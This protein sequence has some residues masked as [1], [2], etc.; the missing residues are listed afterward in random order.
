VTAISGRPK[1]ELC[2]LTGG[3]GERSCPRSATT[4]RSV[5]VDRAPNLPIGRWTFYHWAIVPQTGSRTFA[6][7]FYFY[8]ELKIEDKNP[9]ICNALDSLVYWSLVVSVVQKRWY[10]LHNRNKNRHRTTNNS[11]N[12]NGKVMKQYIFEILIP[13]ILKK[14]VS[15]FLEESQGTSVTC[16][17]Y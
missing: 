3:W 6:Y 16:F 10:T 8:G 11:M 17:Q 14:I 9:R 2:F 5:A 4:I 13:A 15:R 12:S 7:S 1:P